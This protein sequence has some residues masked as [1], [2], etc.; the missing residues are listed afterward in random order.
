MTRKMSGDGY[1]MEKIVDRASVE[2]A[3]CGLWGRSKLFIWSEFRSK[4]KSSEIWAW[5]WKRNGISMI[6]ISFTETCLELTDFSVTIPRTH[7]HTF[8]FSLTSYRASV[9]NIGSISISNLEEQPQQV[10]SYCS[11]LNCSGWMC[12][13]KVC[14]IAINEN[15]HQ[16]NN[17]TVQWFTVTRKLFWQTETQKQV[18]FLCYCF[19]FLQFFVYIYSFI[20]F[21]HCTNTVFFCCLLFFIFVIVFATRPTI[22]PLQND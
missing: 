20:T 2:M 11:W 7:S 4:W 14:Y 5:M 18:I 6:M 10:R 17:R 15:S 8:F 12:N 3:T 9:P 22:Q 1:V 19:E 16:R 21:C 13:Q